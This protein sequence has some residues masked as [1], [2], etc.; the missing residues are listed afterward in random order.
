[1]S[2]V[3][4]PEILPPQLLVADAKEEVILLLR[5]LDLPPQRAKEVFVQWAHLVGAV[6]TREDIEKLLLGRQL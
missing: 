5:R 1:M 4:G 6:F 2:G 3:P